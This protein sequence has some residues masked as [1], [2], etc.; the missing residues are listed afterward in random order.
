MVSMI[1]PCTGFV[2]QSCEY[3]IVSALIR[4]PLSWIIINYM[5]K[6]KLTGQNLGRVFNFRSGRVHAVHLMCYRVKLQ[7]LKLK[8]WPKQLLGSRPLDIALAGYTFLSFKLKI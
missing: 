8:T 1:L 7:N 5:E 2:R 3:L 4:A 6:L